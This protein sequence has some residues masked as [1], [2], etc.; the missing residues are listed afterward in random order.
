MHE[1]F[2]KFPVFFHLTNEK[3]LSKIVRIMNNGKGAREISPAPFLLSGSIYPDL[4]QIIFIC[5]SLAVGNDVFKGR[6][7]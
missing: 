3:T 6:R 4:P 1:E 7:I 2:I 5:N